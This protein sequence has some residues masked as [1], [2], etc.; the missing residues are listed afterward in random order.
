MADT[1]SRR[2]NDLEGIGRLAAPGGVDR[3]WNEEP[4]FTNYKND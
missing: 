1:I 2:T 4:G 3:R